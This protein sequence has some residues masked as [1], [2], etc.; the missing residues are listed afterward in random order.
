MRTAVE[1]TLGRDAEAVPKARRFVASSLVGEPDEMM[2]D[3]QLVVTELVTNAML[4]GEPPVTVRLALYDASIRVEVQ[5]AGRDVP[6]VVPASPAPSLGSMTGRGLALVA[7]LASSWGVDAGRSRGKVIWAEIAPRTDDAA[8]PGSPRVAGEMAAGVHRGR[9]DG[10]RHRVLLG[11]IPTSLLGSSRAHVD[12]VIRELTLLKG[13]GEPLPAALDYLTSLPDAMVDLREQ[14]R[15][16]ALAAAAEGASSAAVELEV[17][18]SIAANGERFLQ[19]M[20]EADRLARGGLLLTLA[21]SPSQRVLRRWW[22]EAVRSQLPG[23]AARPARPVQPLAEALVEA[24]DGKPG[25]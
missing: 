24:L 19:A 2:A 20:D 23:L 11:D 3:I 8:R 12:S 13:G 21:A 14:V 16:Q 6:V 5:D 10:P 18:A 1:L 25:T 17:P 7:G 9:S 15:R 22:L 4:H